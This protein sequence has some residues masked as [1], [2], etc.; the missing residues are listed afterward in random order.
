MSHTTSRGDDFYKYRD[1]C[2]QR[3]QTFGNLDHCQHS[4]QLFRLKQKKTLPPT[5]MASISPSMRWTLY[6]L[7]LIGFYGTWIRSALNGTLSI[8]FRILHATRTLPGSDLPLKSSITGIYWPLDYLLNMLITFF[9]QA[10]DGSHPSTTL[11]SLYFAGQHIA[12]I[13]TTYV[14]SY[15]SSR[16]QSWKLR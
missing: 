15:K 1:V 9:W 7:G 14:D 16:A 3:L 6:T 2:T 10:V 11:F 12:V 8:V 13:V 5:A 4:I